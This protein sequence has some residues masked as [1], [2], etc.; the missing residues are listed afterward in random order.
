[1]GE[2]EAIDSRFKICKRV[3]YDPLKTASYIRDC[4]GKKHEGFVLISDD[5][6]FAFLDVCTH[7]AIVEAAGGVVFNANNEVLL[8]K[9]LGKWDLPKG[10]MEGEETNE[11]S[12]IREVEEECGITG[13]TIE[14]ALTDTFHVYKLKN[15]FHLKI[16]HWYTMHV[17]GVPELTPQKEESIT[18]A[19]WKPW[20]EVNPDTL[21][22]Y[23]SIAELLKDV[24]RN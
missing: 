5:V 1:M 2:D 18:Q 13:L 16:T 23:I 3:T 17:D 21:D 9:R 15:F 7:F 4:E 10:K 14:K 22:T 24:E 6:E 20:A 11:Q 8:I 12:A 19:I